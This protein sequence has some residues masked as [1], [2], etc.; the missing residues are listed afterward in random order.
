MSSD[1]IEPMCVANQR[2]KITVRA[3]DTGV[4]QACERALV[5]G[6]APESR[7]L[8]R[9]WRYAGVEILRRAIGA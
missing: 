4:C 8:A 9:A 7:L 3:R 5:D 1:M 2:L 6:Y